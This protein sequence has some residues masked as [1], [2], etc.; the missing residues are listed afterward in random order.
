MLDGSTGADRLIGG[1]GN[2]TNVV[3]DVGDIVLTRSIKGWI[4]F[5][6]HTYTLGVNLENLTYSGMTDQVTIQNWYSAPT[7]AQVDQLI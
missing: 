5:R 6:A 2:D 3:E 4:R 7:T 1:A